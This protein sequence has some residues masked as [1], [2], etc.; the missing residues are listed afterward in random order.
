MISLDSTIIPAIIIFLA[1]I[2]VLNRLLFKP[3][4]TIQAERESRTTGLISE[5]RSK[6]SHQL[7]LFN[8]YQA[9]IKNARLEA[10][11]KQEQLRNEAM[12]KRAE[13]LGNARTAGE[14]MIQDSRASILS[15]VDSAKRQLE[16][17]AQELARG[18]AS[19]ILGRPALDADSS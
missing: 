2:V 8:E 13:V 15:Q 19:N 3:L 1:L 14:Q 18:I 10:Y 7:D 16:R 4:Q 9:T 6:M 11:R 5:A 12:K 17:E